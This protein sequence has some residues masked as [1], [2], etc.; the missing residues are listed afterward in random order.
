VVVFIYLLF[1]EKATNLGGFGFFNAW[2]GFAK[3]YL[4]LFVIGYHFQ[5]FVLV[6]FW[7]VLALDVALPLQSANYRFAWFVPVA[8]VSSRLVLFGFVYP[9]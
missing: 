4:D 1:I 6:E 7:C 9:C 3:Y 8:I 5:W 2:I